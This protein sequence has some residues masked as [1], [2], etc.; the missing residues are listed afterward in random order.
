MERAVDTKALAALRRD[1]KR[2]APEVR[3]QL[4]R[5]LKQV[6]RDAARKAGDLAPQQTGRLAKGYKPSVTAGKG[7]AVVN[8]QVYAGQHEY[9]RIIHLRRGV[10][11]RATPGK[12]PLPKN[13]RGRAGKT[14]PVDRVF[15][16]PNRAVNIGQY[17]IKRGQYARTG[18]DLTMVAAL[19]RID[20]ACRDAADRAL[21]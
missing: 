9:G 21:S 8:R 3:R 4:D 16:G 2:V 14:V 10:P 6:A 18:V 11:Y 12:T 7:V 17:L 19:A 20:R 5:E 1:L 13:G 15:L